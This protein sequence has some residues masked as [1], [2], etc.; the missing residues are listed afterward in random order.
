MNS[1]KRILLFIILTFSACLSVPMQGFAWHELFSAHKKPILIGTA[2]VAAALMGAAMYRYWWG[3]NDIRDIANNRVF[4][5][6]DGREISDI[7]EDETVQ[8]FKVN[9]AEWC[10]AI[11]GEY[12]F[13]GLKLWQRLSAE[14]SIQYVALDSVHG[15]I[16]QHEVANVIQPVVLMQGCGKNGEGNMCGYLLMAIARAIDELV[17]DEIVVTSF[18]IRQRAAKI[19]DKVDDNGCSLCHTYDARNGEPVEAQEIVNA[20]KNLKF[21]GKNFDSNICEYR[22]NEQLFIEYSIGDHKGKNLKPMHCLYNNGSHWVMITVFCKHGK[23]I[24]YYMDP[25]NIRLCT[26]MSSVLDAIRSHSAGGGPEILPSAS[27]TG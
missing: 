8:Q 5:V 9:A 1:Y 2:M 25:L 4:T 15:H 6:S 11:N 18:T 27:P 7:K 24:L 3:G 14:N 13:N 12:F 17:A 26:S 19:W 21:H 23:T 20:A 10:D 16:L 22:E